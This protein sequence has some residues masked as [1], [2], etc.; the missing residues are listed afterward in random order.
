MLEYPLSFHFLSGF[1]NPGWELGVGSEETCLMSIFSLWAL[2]SGTLLVMRLC[3]MSLCR[4]SSLVCLHLS[5]CK[6][7]LNSLE[8]L[9]KPPLS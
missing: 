8:V 1:L 7:E 4:L 6:A 9:K 3:R 2:I 5:T